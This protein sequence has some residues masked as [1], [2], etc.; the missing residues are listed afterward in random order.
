M[1][2]SVSRNVNQ[3]EQSTSG[4]SIAKLIDQAIQAN[5]A[6]TAAAAVRRDRFR[7][8]NCQKPIESA[9]AQCWT[10]DH[11]VVRGQLLMSE[12]RRAQ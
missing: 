9:A 3:R 1:Y 10:L 2:H 6:T 8:S 4:H 11:E 12:Q 5:D 7:I